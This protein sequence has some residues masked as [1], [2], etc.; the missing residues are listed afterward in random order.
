LAVRASNRP[1]Q[2]KSK[3]AVTG[4]ILAKLLAVC[5]GDRL[6]DLRDRALLLM[7]FASG[8]RRRSEVAG[9]RIEDLVDEEPVRA[10]PTDEH[11]P[12]LPCLT[13]HLGR[14]KTTSA[15]DDEHVVLIGRPV[16]AIKHWLAEAKIETGPVFRR[17][18]Q[19][20]A[21]PRL[22]CS[23]RMGYCLI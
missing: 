13:I 19:W 22:N 10:N 5:A 4:D 18:D 1:R 17:I 21:L 23:L 8:G 20:G 6:V 7:A 15:D 2:R 12:L 11:S 9:L 16:T 3:K 14:T